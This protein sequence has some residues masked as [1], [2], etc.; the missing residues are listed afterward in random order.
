MVSQEFNFD[1]PWG[2]LLKVITALLTLLLL[3]LFTWMAFSG[4]AET[5]FQTVLYL[6]LPIVV[7][8]GSMLFM[9]RGYDITESGISVRRL[10][11][12]TRIDLGIVKRVEHD[13]GAMRGAI[14]T[15]GN[16]GFFSFS[17]R[18]RSSR[19]GSFRAYVTDYGNCVV[20]ETLSATVVVSPDNPLLFAEIL[21]KRIW[22]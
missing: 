11:W 19:L 17:G 18:F 7:I 4:R 10:L 5:L 8:V 21:G 22:S 6:L 12:N 2:R 3:G 9:V 13:P 20:I 16:G 1:A 14:R 15:W